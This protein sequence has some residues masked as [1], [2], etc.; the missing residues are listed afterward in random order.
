[1][2]G[3]RPQRPP[4][5]N[6]RAT[7]WRAPFRHAT[8]WHATL[9]A[10]LTL[11]LASVASAADWTVQLVDVDAA[12]VPRAASETQVE[13][14]TWQGGGDRA[15][16]KLRTAKQTTNDQGQLVVAAPKAGQHH[17]LAFDEAGHRV[18]ARLRAD[19]LQVRR[20]ART[21]TRQE[22]A[23]DVRAN[24]EVRD[25][26]LRVWALYT[27]RVE[28]SG[29]VRLSPKAPLTL[30]LLAPAVRG[31]VL[32]RGTLPSA[33]RHVE[34]MLEGDAEVT[35]TKGALQLHG[36]V[37]P[38]RPV[39]VRVR[40]PIATIGDTAHLGLRGVVGE[41][42]L[43]VAAVGVRPARP[44]V[45]VNRP[46]R[47]GSQNEGRERLAGVALLRPLAEGETVL[48]TVHDLPTQAAWPRRAL[49]GGFVLLCLLAGAAFIRRPGS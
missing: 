49:G 41:T 4:A 30:P 5:A 19:A 25:S 22:L 11:S 39:S 15:A 9:C 6:R 28:R 14:T 48:L 33:A 44:R 12:G 26:G 42:Q 3:A 10:A 7:R 20:F 34:V 17:T 37:A 16:K 27:F 23:L 38:G 45:T 35:R 21:L 13:L 43:A 29:V 1:M 32:D 18:T 40:Y 24:F 46:A 31:E 8:R 36:T 2:K 47:G